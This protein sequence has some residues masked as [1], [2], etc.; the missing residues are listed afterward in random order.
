MFNI[1]KSGLEDALKEAD[2]LA[3]VSAGA[4]RAPS[5]SCGRREVPK[6]EFSVSWHALSA[7]GDERALGDGLSKGANEDRC[8]GERDVCDRDREREP[9][10]PAARFLEGFGVAAACFSS[11]ISPK[12]FTGKTG[13]RRACAS[14]C[15]WNKR[16]ASDKMSDPYK[17]K[18]NLFD[19]CAHSGVTKWKR[20]VT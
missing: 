16:S 12:A 14:P 1:L 6:C 9:E 8:A 3:L 20:C 17:K 11:V 13:D 2:V 7:L 5:P 15:A 19:M 18:G 10:T 4:P